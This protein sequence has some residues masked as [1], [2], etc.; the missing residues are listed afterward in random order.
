MSE[1][2]DTKPWWKY[3]MLWMVVGGPAVVVVASF[4]TY[5]LAAVGQDPIIKDPVHAAEDAE[6]ER[7]LVLQPGSTS[8]AEQARNHAATGVVPVKVPV[9]K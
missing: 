8:P 4:V 2:K 1:T 9:S 6:V 7:H 5:Y 3:G